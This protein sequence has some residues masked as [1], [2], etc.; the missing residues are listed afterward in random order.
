MDFRRIT[1]RPTVVIKQAAVRLP[2]LRW[3]AWAERLLRRHAPATAAWHLLD[4][5]LRQGTPRH[6]TL[7][8]RRSSL[9]LG[10]YL[11]IPA[12]R[13]MVSPAA[14]SD[15]DL[16]ESAGWRAPLAQIVRASTT[17]RITRLTERARLE[18]HYREAPSPLA[19][20]RQSDLR[21]LNTHTLAAVERIYARQ[22]QR[23]EAWG[24]AA[25]VVTQVVKQPEIPAVPAAAQANRFEAES[26][27]Q[28]LRHWQD[29]SAQAAPQ[30]DI[31]RLTD[32]VIRSIDQR[33]TASRE[34]FGR[35]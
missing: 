13:V 11:T 7:I 30:A 1:D 32:Q 12:A 18:Q 6:E 16:P 15:R 17:E 33:L 21:L 4:A 2:A 8:D 24:A 27:F 22:G 35:R 31:Q 28:P 3:A 9:A 26:A 10:L 34:R 20:L 25:P 14:L 19:I 23:Y 29:A 5:I